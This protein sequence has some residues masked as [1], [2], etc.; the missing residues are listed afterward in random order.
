MDIKNVSGKILATAAA[1]AFVIGV[2]GC[3]AHAP[4]AGNTSLANCGKMACKGMSSCK[5]QN[6]CNGKVDK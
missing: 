5:G 3:A 4:A 6:G 2:S 1:A